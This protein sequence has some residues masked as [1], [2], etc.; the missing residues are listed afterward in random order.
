MRAWSTCF[1][2]IL[3][4]GRGTDLHS[5]YVTHH[6]PHK[7]DSVSDSRRH[8]ADD[9]KAAGKLTV[10]GL[11]GL[12]DIT[13]SVHAQISPFGIAN[14]EGPSKTTGMTRFIYRTIRFFTRLSGHGLEYSLERFRHKLGQGE[15]SPQKAALIAA[16]NGVL[17]HY[18]VEKENALAIPM[19]IRAPGRMVTPEELEQSSDSSYLMMIHGLCMSDYCWE[20]NGQQRAVDL[21]EHLKAK[22][23]YLHYNS[24]LHISRNGS[25]FDQLMERYFGDRPGVQ[26]SLLTHS[27]GGLVARSALH[28][29]QQ[30][31]HRWPQRINK[32]F[33]LGTPHHG[34]MLEKAGNWVDTLLEGNSISKPIAKLGKIRSHGITDLRYGYVT[35]EDWEGR[36]PFARPHR[37]PKQ[38][39]L[40]EQISCY[41]IAASTDPGA[42]RIHDGI[43][44][45]GLVTVDSA[46]GKHKQAARCLKFAPDHT[47]VIRGIAHLDLL[48]DAQVFDALRKWMT[49]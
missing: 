6:S 10:E 39:P 32:L 9:L 45:D 47:Q 42:G 13:E 12:I 29:A 41:A 28:F 25:R 5:L 46:L 3:P 26:I 36:D 20:R 24:G 33:F 16:L 4:A 15:E 2:T 1:R 31:H 34:A 35:Q 22:P 19:S 38:I 30:K 17:G 21:A 8:Q 23:L 37:R 14:P 11:K 49:E 44:G 18:L 48:S 7:H 43:I 40:P 27:M